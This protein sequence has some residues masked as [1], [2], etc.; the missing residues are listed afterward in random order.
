VKSYS[1]VQQHLLNLVDDFNNTSLFISQNV[2][3]AKIMQSQTLV[4]FMKC[5]TWTGK[6]VEGN[7]LG[8][9][10]GNAWKK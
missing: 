5:E 2:S 4:P 3:T 10:P 7:G 9:W 6:D 8:Y 1:Q